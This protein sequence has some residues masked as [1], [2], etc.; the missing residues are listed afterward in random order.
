MRKS[1]IIIK[2]VF[3]IWYT[4]AQIESI[5]KQDTKTSKQRLKKIQSCP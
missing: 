4:N 5:Q 2:S 1:F 3:C